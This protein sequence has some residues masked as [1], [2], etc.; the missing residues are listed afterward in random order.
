MNN[1]SKTIILLIVLFNSI[2]CHAQSYIQGKYAIPFNTIGAIPTLDNNSLLS[3]PEAYNKISPL[4]SHRSI[5]DY[6]SKIENYSGQ[7]FS[8]DN[9]VI[10]IYAQ[11]LPSPSPNRYKILHTMKNSFDQDFEEEIKGNKYFSEIKKIKNYYSFINY[12]KVEN[13]AKEA[14]VV[15]EQGRYMLFIKVFCKNDST[16]INQAISTLNNIVNNITFK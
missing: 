6:Y 16:S 3:I 9:L 7:Y 8:K 13:Y 14:C 1:I 10:N 11:H 5:Y 2:F 15:D 12:S 4:F